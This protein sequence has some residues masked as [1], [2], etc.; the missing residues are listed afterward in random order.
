MLNYNSHWDFHPCYRCWENYTYNVYCYACA[1]RLER[2]A[3]A[4]ELA[5]A[6][7]M[8]ILKKDEDR[9]QFCS[10]LRTR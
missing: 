5:P 8:P 7:V 1:D 9:I 6:P 2:Y 10:V 4:V 3:R